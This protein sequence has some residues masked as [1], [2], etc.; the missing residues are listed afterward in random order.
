M[1][2]AENPPNEESTPIAGFWRR[3]LGLLIDSIILGAV[4]WALG[5]VFLDFFMGLGPWG[6]VVGFFIALLYFG[7]MNSRV[8]SGQTFGK[9]V[10]KTKVINHKGEPLGL[11]KSILRYLVLGVPFF[12]NGAHIPQEILFSWVG[13]VVS[14]LIFG[15]GSSII[16]LILFNRRTR[17]SLH[18]LM[19][20]SYVV[21]ADTP[22][23]PLNTTTWKGHYA[24]VALLFLCS[25]ALPS[26][27]S[28]K[29]GNSEFFKPLLSLQREIQKEPEVSAVSINEG[30]NVF[31]SSNSGTQKTTSLVINVF[32][33][34]KF[35][36]QDGIVNKVA[37]IA[38]DRLPRA[39]QKNMVS[40]AVV[41]GYDIGISSFWRSQGYRNSPEEWKKRL[42]EGQRKPG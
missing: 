29:F 19:V 41:W 15:F 16:Y 22:Q 37:Q 34:K 30:Q 32:L 9:R 3:V 21:K 27:L 1:S 28:A 20:G 7:L 17:Q 18:D 38:F 4:G 42:A 6:R 31:P 2:E 33:R 8:F 5:L 25:A 13:T 12:L 23:S 36:D 10:V 24:V 14:V 11:D 39:S 35:P 40:V 26:V